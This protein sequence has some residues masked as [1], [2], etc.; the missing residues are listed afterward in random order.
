[1]LELKNI[2]VSY[3]DKKVLDNLSL[4][5]SQAEI[6]GLVA[7]NGMGKTTLFNVIANFLKPNKGKVIINDKYQYKSERQE[8]KIHQQLA[9]LPDQADLFEDLSGVEHMKLYKNMWKSSK[10]VEDIYQSLDM[11]SY[12]KRKVK[13]YSLGMRQRLCFA[14]L[15]CTD[16]EIMLMDEVMNGLD[17]ANVS[18]ISNQL[19]EM[20]QE[21]KLLFIAS[22]LLSNLDLYADRVLFLKDGDFVHEQHRANQ[23]EKY[24]KMTVLPSD[25]DKLSHIHPFPTNHLYIAENLLCIP[26]S[27]MTKEEQ[28]D[29]MLRLSNDSDS[30]IRLGP[31]GTQEY[32]ERFYHEEETEL[33][34]GGER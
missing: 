27:A 17:V 33:P 14:M 23:H 10:K 34:T 16:T 21:G 9:T 4:T 11:E 24:I 6:I 5:A 26:T 3:K 29:W 25:Y 2:K 15:R 8:I 30:E 20:K 1:M 18:L 19:I 31:L 13:T 32:Y 12:V 7:P 28:A 22:H